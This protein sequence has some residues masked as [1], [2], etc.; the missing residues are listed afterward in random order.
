[1]CNFAQFLHKNLLQ[2][3][4][5]CLFPKQANF[6]NAEMWERQPTAGFPALHI[7]GPLTHRPI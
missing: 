2:F 5:N 1:M 4:V 3:L 7:A 6:R